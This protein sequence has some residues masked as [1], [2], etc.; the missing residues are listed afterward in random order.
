MNSQLIENLILSRMQAW[1]YFDVKR[2]ERT[3]RKCVVPKTG[4]WSRVTIKG[5]INH[6]QSM[7][8]KPCILQVGTVIVQ[9]FDRIGNGTREIKARAD[10]LANHL[11]CYTVDKLELLAPSVIDI[12][13]DGNG[14]YQINVLI[15]YR[16][17]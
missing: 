9:L 14:F 12:G 17:Y 11:G 15:P 16:Y 3:N 4:V 13:D 6:I 10:S 1:Q 8:D 2:I 7:S 5:G